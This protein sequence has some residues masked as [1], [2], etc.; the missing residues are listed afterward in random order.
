MKVIIKA[1]VIQD[2]GST[3]QETLLTLH[4]TTEQDEPLGLSIH[5]EKPRQIKDH[6]TRHYHTLFGVIPIKGL[7]LYRCQ[8]EQATTKSVSLLSEWLLDNTHPELKFIEA[9]WASLMSYDLTVERLKD[10]L[11]ISQT[12][13]S[14]TVRNHLVSVAK[15]Q[16]TELAT[17]ADF[18][19]KSAYDSEKL[20]RPGKP[21]VIGLDGG[22]VRD[23][24]NRKN[25]FEIITGKAYSE[26]VQAK[27]FGYVHV[28]EDNPRKR[29]L[30]VLN[31][32]GVQTNQQIT[33][34]SD[35]ADNLRMMQIGIYPEAEHILDWFHISMRL[36]VLNQC[37]KGILTKSVDIGTELQSRLEKTKWYLW[38]GNVGNA[39]DQL[40]SCLCICDCDEEGS[41]CKN[42]K[43]KKMGRYLDEMM[44]YIA[45]NQFMIPNY[46]ERYRYG[47][48]ISTAFVESTVHEVIAKRMAKK[49]QMQWSQQ[50]AHYLLQTRVAV[51]NGELESIFHRWYPKLKNTELDAIA[52]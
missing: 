36:T 10:I 31:A 42:S 11:P 20:P 29:L 37:I 22:Y 49:Q 2:D 15:Q 41:H 46:G 44:T 26:N 5:G 6:Q 40:D 28:L 45:N 1:V 4:K 52:A 23:C 8:C 12:L 34:L 25:N 7:R 43:N 50:G 39:L 51:L 18:L 27:R 19:E 9:K 35:G 17:Q 48:P 47:E 24:H 3:H 30:S 38:H 14:A 16:E 33:F 13:N 21:M 32:Q